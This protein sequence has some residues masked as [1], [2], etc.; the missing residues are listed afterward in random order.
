M[1]RS[2]EFETRLMSRRGAVKALGAVAGAALAGL[3]AVCAG[4]DIM[5]PIGALITGGGRGI[6]LC[7]CVYWNV[8]ND[9]KES[10]K[11]V[12]VDSHKYG[13]YASLFCERFTANCRLL[14][15]FAANCL[16][17][18]AG[19]ETKSKIDTCLKKLLS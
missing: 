8:V 7:C 1:P 9:K 5:H 12:L 19:L 11:L 3:V 2:H 6:G 18:I 16:W 14:F 10:R 4:S 13:F 15:Y 17:W